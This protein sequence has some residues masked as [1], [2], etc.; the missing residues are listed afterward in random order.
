MTEELK[1]A[2]EKAKKI[3]DEAKEKAKLSIEKAKEKAKKIIEKAKSRKQKGGRVN[4]HNIDIMSFYDEQRK[5]F[6]LPGRTDIIDKITLA[7]RIAEHIPYMRDLKEL[8]LNGNKLGDKNILIILEAVKNS[9]HYIENIEI[10]DN[11]ITSENY[12]KN[13]RPIIDFLI[14]KRRLYRLSTENNFI[15]SDYPYTEHTGY[16]HDTPMPNILKTN[17]MP[18]QI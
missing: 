6:E 1:I 16:M 17:N 10:D 13:L 7:Q 9:D 14:A 4:A 11:K 5:I 3:I 8:I 15:N 2:K 12:H 18:N